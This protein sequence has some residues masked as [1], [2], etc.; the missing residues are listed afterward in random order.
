MT[1]TQ[2]NL[3]VSL[4]V[5]VPIQAVIVRNQ[6]ILSLVVQLTLEVHVLQHRQVRLEPRQGDGGHVH[7][8]FGRVVIKNLVDNLV[9]L[10]GI[11]ICCTFVTL[12]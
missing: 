3:V 11:Y 8:A 1:L 6:L 4:P 10:G 9:R 12:G 7:H 2:Y 5:H